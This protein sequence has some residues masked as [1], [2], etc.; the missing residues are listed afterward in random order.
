MFWKLFGRKEKQKQKEEVR[1]EDLMQWFDEKKKDHEA[2]ASKR[3]GVLR[4]EIKE[5]LIK[6]DENLDM[7]ENAKLRNEN[8]P[9]KAI[10]YM[11][12]NRE[13]YIKRVKLLKSSINIPDDLE[14]VPEFLEK[15][16][17]EIHSFSK[18]TYRQ[19]MIL[20]EFLAH[21]SGAIAQNIK[22]IDSKI[23]SIKKALSE[24]NIDMIAE[25]SGLISSFVEKHNAREETEKKV[26]ESAFSLK[27]K[28]S[29][30]NETE[31]LLESI[32]SSEDYS[33]I[34]QLVSQKKEI[35]ESVRALEYE[36]REKFSVL[37]RPLRKYQKISFEDEKL[38]EEYL[39]DALHALKDDLNMRIIGAL[40][41]VRSIVEKG[42]LGLKDK[43]AEKVVRTIDEIDQAYLTGILARFNKMMI[44]RNEIDENI[45][46]SD[47]LKQKRLAE[48]ELARVSDDI[49][50]L[51]RKIAA[52]KD[53]IENLGIPKAKETITANIS[54][55]FG[56]EIEI[57]D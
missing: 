29:K 2:S 33:K 45:D 13:A 22:L 1:K 8:I 23:G 50:S 41:K 6:L 27:K 26:S 5:E 38:V 24:G 52:G 34:R 20:Q 7:L 15:F 57:V 11:I 16:D 51:K 47:V 48:E 12:G 46:A 44:Q 4:S 39:N 53:E 14:K 40:S 55:M 10:Q 9:P 35:S 31:S 32:R 17:S 18:A 56:V 37:D 30:K 25:T 49:E 54:D 3:V 19:Y 36:L 21:E 42:D 43:Q 28:E